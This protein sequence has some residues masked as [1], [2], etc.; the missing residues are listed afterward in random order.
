ML[1][2]NEETLL[3]LQAYG[4]LAL[5]EQSLSRENQLILLC[6]HVDVKPVKKDILQRVAYTL[7]SRSGKG[8]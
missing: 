8:D 6:Q 4:T 2:L 1:A 7:P 5:A 3:Q